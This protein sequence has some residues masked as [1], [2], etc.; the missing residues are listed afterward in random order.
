MALR[1]SK[2]NDFTSVQQFKNRIDGINLPGFC[3]EIGTVRVLVVIVLKQLAHQE[4]IKGKR[5]PGMIAIVKILIP[6]FV[7]TPVDRRS[8]DW[9]HQ[10][11]NGQKQV[12]PPGR[13]KKDIKN[14][15]SSRPEQAGSPAIAKAVEPAPG[16]V[17]AQKVLRNLKFVLDETVI[18]FGRLPHH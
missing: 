9:A 11:V 13:G 12:H 1:S 10:K 16:W 15:I 17:I 2:L 3:R 8:M 7:A 6:I 4:Q 18:D 14:H 5:I